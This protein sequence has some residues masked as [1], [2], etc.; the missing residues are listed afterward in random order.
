MSFALLT[1]Q[2]RS[3][4]MKI[5]RILVLALVPVGV[6]AAS[7]Q[8][9]VKADPDHY[10]VI[11]DNASVRVLKISYAPGATSKVHQHPDSIVIPLTES[12]VRFTLPDGKSE[13]TTLASES[14][15]YSP[16]GTHTPTNV[17]TKAME[18]VL[19][20]FKPAAPGKAALPTSRAGMETKVLAEGP[21]AT[22]YRSTASATFAEPAGTTHEF[23]QVVIALAPGTQMSLSID[24][25]P[26]KTTWARGDVQFIGRGVKHESKNTGGKPV[27]M[28]IVAIK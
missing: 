24:G 5:W 14:A 22:A 27:D 23:D 13:D 1:Y 8:D 18:A 26:A 11:L 4:R 10:K 16:A 15:M 25:K 28:V 12:K 17:G 2:P 7:A 9:A 19:V 20:E 6:T 3:V 21:R